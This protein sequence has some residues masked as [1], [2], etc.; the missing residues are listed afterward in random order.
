[1]AGD[2]DHGVEMGMI[3][4]QGEVEE[5]VEADADSD[6][7][8]TERFEGKFSGEG[9]VHVKGKVSHRGLKRLKTE[10][11]KFFG[12]RKAGNGVALTSAFPST[13]WER[14]EPLHLR[15][16]L[17]G[18]FGLGVRGDEKGF[19]LDDAEAGVAK[20]HGR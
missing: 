17:P 13:T 8:E 11:E 16:F 14:G 18:G 10:R 12:L 6:G 5:V 7:F 20:F 9:V 2:D 1:M 19:A 4:R 3:E 15:S